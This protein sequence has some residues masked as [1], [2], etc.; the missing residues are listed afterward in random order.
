MSAYRPVTMIV[1]FECGGRCPHITFLDGQTS[2][3]TITNISRFSA[4][5]HQQTFPEQGMGVLSE[6]RKVFAISCRHSF[7]GQMARRW[8]G[9][10][11][12]RGRI[13]VQDS[14][15]PRQ[16]GP[17][18]DFPFYFLS[19]GKLSLGH[20]APIVSAYKN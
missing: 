15:T 5:C 13:E 14:L 9:N 2:P 3:F 12:V 19:S 20:I 16:I 7:G 1:L 6:R 10:E 18:R 17:L 11:G 8:K 4:W